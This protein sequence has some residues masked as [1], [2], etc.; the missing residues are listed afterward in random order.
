MEG[1]LSLILTKA[2]KIKDRSFQLSAR[3]KHTDENTEEWNTGL[4]LRKLLSHPLYQVNYP[5]TELLF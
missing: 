3:L 4:I 5:M 1:Y 2:G